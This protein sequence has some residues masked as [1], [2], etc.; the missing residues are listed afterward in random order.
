MKLLKNKETGELG[1]LIINVDE[2]NDATTLCVLDPD[3]PLCGNS[4]LGEYNSLAELCER[5]EDYEDDKPWA[6][7]YGEEYWS[8]RA[9][10]SICQDSW[11]SYSGDV[12][13]YLFGNCFRTKEEAKQ[14]AEKLKAWKRLEDAGFKFKGW[15]FNGEV[16]F[17]FPYPNHIWSQKHTEDLDL[18]FGGDDE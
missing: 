4:V 11:M 10:G 12:D 13:K 8:I 16:D 3:S 1:K 9:D 14:A 18:L 6:P 15:D 2:E 17:E 7:K 5:W